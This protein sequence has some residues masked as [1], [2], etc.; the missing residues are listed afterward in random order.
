MGPMIADD[1][2]SAEAGNP[3][4]ALEPEVHSAGVA[5]PSR[6]LVLSVRERRALSALIYLA[7]VVLILLAIA[8]VRDMWP[9][10][11]LVAVMFFTWRG[12]Y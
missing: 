11:R 9:P 1:P 4:A 12:F 10:F 3:G 5:Q 6:S 8:L 2:S 7:P